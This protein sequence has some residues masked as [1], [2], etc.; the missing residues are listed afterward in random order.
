M[1][2]GLDLRKSSDPAEREAL[3]RKADT[4]G[5]WAVLVGGGPSGTEV[6]EAA[7]I[8]ISTNNVHLAVWVDGSSEHPLTL[9]EEI[10]ILDHLS[11]RRALPV[12]AAEPQII[13]RVQQFLD[14]SSVDGFHLVPPPAQTIVPVWDASEVTVIEL[15]GDLV[16]DRVTI[17][18]ERDS[19]TTHL[20]VSWPGNI[21]TMVR[22]LS[23][24]ALVNDFPQLVADLADSLPENNWSQ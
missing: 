5:V 3:A 24:R 9:A 8:A 15:T 20:F 18:A 23:T 16:K 10:S 21:E 13:T 4:L 2:I 14:G 12:I 17:D 1:R 6:S 7:S 11:D 19:G 22:H